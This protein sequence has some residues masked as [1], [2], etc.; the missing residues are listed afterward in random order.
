MYG[1]ESPA[2]RGERTEPL[3]YGSASPAQR[4]ER[5]EPLLDKP[6][7]DFYHEYPGA[8]PPAW[9]VRLKFLS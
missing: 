8:R 2:Q 7:D 4:G 6:E 9:C 3:L 1:S 5:T